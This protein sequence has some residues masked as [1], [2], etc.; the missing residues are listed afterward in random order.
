ML[1]INKTQD[2]TIT[3]A[4]IFD[5]STS[6]D[7]RTF[8]DTIA[9]S[10]DVDFKELTYISSAGLG[11]LLATQKRLLTRGER[12]TLVHMPPQLKKIFDM[13]MFGVMFEI[14]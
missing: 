6:D 8:F 1:Q 3:L 14:K 4:G 12:L 10:C 2:G 5:G 11:V 13:A 9:T 7:A